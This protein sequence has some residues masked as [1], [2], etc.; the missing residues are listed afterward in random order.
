MRRFSLL[1]FVVLFGLSLTTVP[2]QAADTV[3]DLLK[4]RK[5][6]GK[7]VDLIS[8]AG[9]KD[10]FQNKDTTITVFAPTDS[11]ISDISSAHM[12]KIKATKESL[13]SFVK[14]HVVI[15]SRITSSS[16]NQRKF[17][18]A[19]ASGDMILFDGANKNGTK[20]NGGSVS[21]SDL[22]LGNN[23]VHIVSVAFIPSV[24]QDEPK[25]EEQKIEEPKKVEPKKV[26]PVATKSEPAVE[27]P[28]A[29]SVP[30]STAK[31]K[32]T[33]AKGEVAVPVTSSAPVPE[34]SAVVA[35]PPPP[36]PTPVEAPK[37]KG[38]SLFGKTFGGE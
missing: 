1:L 38:F 14:Y 16:M 10:I 32:K 13:Q 37:K 23:V 4:S 15:G 12:K 27:A 19:A 18:S 6:L 33:G 5:E 2:A 24:A 28:V 26:E 17:S 8:D 20:I 31:A 34:T 30:L 35:P 11:A 7:F 29:A 21:V 3:Y 36:P 22:S 9:L 25:K